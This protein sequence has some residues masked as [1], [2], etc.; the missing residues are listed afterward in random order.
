MDKFIPPRATFDTAVTS[1]FEF[2]RQFGHGKKTESV[3][4]GRV[5]KSPVRLESFKSSS[6]WWIFVAGSQEDLKRFAVAKPNPL[7]PI[8]ASLLISPQISSTVSL[9]SSSSA[10]QQWDREHLFVYRGL[11]GSSTV[12]LPPGLRDGL[13]VVREGTSDL[14]FVAPTGYGKTKLWMIPHGFGNAGCVSCLLLPTIPVV[15]DVQKQLTQDGIPCVLFGDTTSVA[16]IRTSS[17]LICTL[18]DVLRPSLSVILQQLNTSGRL[19]RIVCDEA[20]CLKDWEDFRLGIDRVVNLRASL[21]PAVPFLFLTATALPSL[22]LKLR[23]ICVGHSGQLTT[24]RM[25]AAF[26]NNIGLQ[27]LECES[28]K[29][30]YECI[31]SIIR[32]RTDNDLALVFCRKLASIDSLEKLLKDVK[33]ETAKCTGQMSMDEKEAAIDDWVVS[34]KVML[35]TSTMCMGINK[36][37]G[38]ASRCGVSSAQCVTV[39]HGG[40]SNGFQQFLLNQGDVEGAENFGVMMEVSRTSGCRWEG[41]VHV[42]DGVEFASCTSQGSTVLC[43]RCKSLPEPEIPAIFRNLVSSL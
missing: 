26:R 20:H 28:E 19:L 23:D 33:I 11:M 15:L 21:V 2:H 13:R 14:L 5:D 10:V 35:S 34:E 36:R 6:A 22:E 39:F 25:P 8:D 27:F 37:S 38:R 16:D 31:T 24:L 12:T 4:Y 1:S 43:D 17:I 42:N 29:A 18:E 7:K 32:E 9:K 40:S 30:V 41:L 3:W